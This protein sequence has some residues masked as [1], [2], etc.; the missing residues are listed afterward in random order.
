MV[1]SR[2]NT[3]GPHQTDQEENQGVEDSFPVSDELATRAELSVSFHE[4]S[5][6]EMIVVNELKDIYDLRE[7]PDRIIFKKLI[8][9]D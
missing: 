2:I 7:K 6:E 1:R 4:A 8:L 3:T 9:R 5:E